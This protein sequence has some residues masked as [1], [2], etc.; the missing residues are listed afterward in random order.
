MC[1]NAHLSDKTV[2]KTQ[3]SD[4]YK[5]Q[6]SSYFWR[7]EEVLIRMRHLKRVSRVGDIV[8]FPG[9]WKV[10]MPYNDPLRNTLDL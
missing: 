6:D 1:Q 2:I 8:P 3:G 4:L 7:E 5:N 9:N 10:S